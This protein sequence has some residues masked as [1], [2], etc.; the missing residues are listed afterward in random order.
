MMTIRLPTG[1]EEMA[2][3][4]AVTPV[5]TEGS[6][7]IRPM[8]GKREIRYHNQPTARYGD[9]EI[10]RKTKNEIPKSED[11]NSIKAPLSFSIGGV[12]NLVVVLND[13]NP[14]EIDWVSFQ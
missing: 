9:A 1:T 13:N 10:L 8:T 2:A 14:V 3:F 12:Q 4:S 7:A 5:A 11:W 6:N